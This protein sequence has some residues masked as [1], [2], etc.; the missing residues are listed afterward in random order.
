MTCRSTRAVDFKGSS[1]TTSAFRPTLIL[2][3]DFDWGCVLFPPPHAARIRGM[4][5]RIITNAAGRL[6]LCIYPARYPEVFSLIHYL[7]WQPDGVAVDDNSAG[8]IIM[9]LART[10][11]YPYIIIRKC[12]TLST[13]DTG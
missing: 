4:I 8:W 1:V 5:N 3:P 2:P 11:L 6:R 10:S 7:P 9:K 13:N 12:V